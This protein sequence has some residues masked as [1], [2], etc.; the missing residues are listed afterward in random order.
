MGMP[1]TVDVRDAD[2]PPAAVA[3]GFACLR[4]V[5][6]TFSTYRPGSEISRLSRGELALRDA[7]PAVRATVRGALRHRRRARAGERRRLCHRRLGDGGARTRL[8]GSPARGYGAMT[9][10]A[11]DEVLCTPAFGRRVVWRA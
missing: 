11:G 4:F 9:I 3:C 2:V 5:D 7:H 6:A 1:V 10:L 8:D